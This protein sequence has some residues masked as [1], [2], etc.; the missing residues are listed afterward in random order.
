VT[1]V[2]QAPYAVSADYYP[3]DA[4]VQFTITAGGGVLPDGNYR[5]SLVG[6]DLR[7][8]AG[9]PV[10]GTSYLD[11]FH[12]QGDVN[13]DRIIDQA[14]VD[15]VQANMGGGPGFHYYEG[16]VNYDGYISQDDLDLVN[17]YFGRIMPAPPAAPDDLFVG[18]QTDSS[19]EL[20]WQDVQTGAVGYR[21]QW[22]FDGQTFDHYINLQR[23]Q[24]QFTQ[25]GLVTWTQTG[26]SQDQR[27]WYRV[28]AYGNNLDTAY[29]P[30]QA[31]T[32][33]LREP[34]DL[35]IDSI[36]EDRVTVSWTPQSGN[37]ADFLVERAI[38]D[39]A[40]G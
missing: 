38:G 31:A 35:S 34:T 20:N 4:L 27:V 25:T 11:F 33:I 16:D 3:E 28:R 7:D 29:T 15:I 24:L 6:E 10:S 32:T 1:G 2:D 18:N 22:S 8:T 12:L 21:V 9:Q 37:Q 5:A 30:K 36:G 26:L 23:A 19:I 17:D 40:F 39:G 14:D 13:E